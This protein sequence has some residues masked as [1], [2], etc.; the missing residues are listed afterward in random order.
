MDEFQDAKST[1]NCVKNYTVS[2][3]KTTICSIKREYK[4][5]TRNMNISEKNI[6]NVVWEEE[7]VGCQKV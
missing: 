2:P 4:V 7:Y 3:S 6:I 1:V 5:L